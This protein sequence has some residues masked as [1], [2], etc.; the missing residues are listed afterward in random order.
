[1]CEMS[2]PDGTLR[3]I[4][5]LDL[6]TGFSLLVPKLPTL[7]AD[8]ASGDFSPTIAGFWEIIGEI[9]GI[10]FPDI[11][12]PGIVEPDISLEIPGLE[13]E[14]ALEIGINIALAAGAVVKAIMLELPVEFI[15]NPPTGSL[16]EW[17]AGFIPDIVA[18]DAALKLAGCI[19]EL[20]G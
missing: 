9:D 11:S 14:L 4:P 18:P 2:L 12:I 1:M 15:M 10:N 3:L 8:F 6:V 20:L 16:P 19:A 7:A 5:G 13:P 17:V